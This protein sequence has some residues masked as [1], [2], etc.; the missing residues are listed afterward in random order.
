MDGCPPGIAPGAGHSQTALMCQQQSRRCAPLGASRHGT[1]SFVGPHLEDGTERA[2]AELLLDRIAANQPWRRLVVQINVHQRRIDSGHS[3]WAEAAE[4]PIQLLA[5][6]P[7][8][9]V[10][11]AGVPTRLGYTGE[12]THG[13][14]L[15][16]I[17]KWTWWAH[18]GGGNAL[19]F[20]QPT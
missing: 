17:S 10:G 12:T 8:G 16:A 14:S 11:S 13:L 20:K 6:P 4:A 15:D 2:R 5:V 19:G 3:V 18:T 7:G 9:M 1:A